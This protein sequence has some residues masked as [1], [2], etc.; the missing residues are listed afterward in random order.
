MCKKF[1]KVNVFFQ[2]QFQSFP[3]VTQSDIG[4]VFSNSQSISCSLYR[5]ETDTEY[6]IVPSQIIT[7]TRTLISTEVNSHVY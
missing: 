2:I 5:A 1:P 3:F 4:Y 6:Q 7:S